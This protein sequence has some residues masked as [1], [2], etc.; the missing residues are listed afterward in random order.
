MALALGV[1]QF[2]FNQGCSQW[3]LWCHKPN[4]C[5]VRTL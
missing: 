1:A 2:S 5:G 4:V 3:Y